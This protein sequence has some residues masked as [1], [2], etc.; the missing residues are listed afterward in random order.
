MNYEQELNRVRLRSFE[1]SLII[2]ENELKNLLLAVDYDSL[3]PVDSLSETI[4][5][6]K[7]LIKDKKQ[8][9]GGE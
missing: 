2:L 9:L 6:L 8:E 1:H 3:S 4:E 7:N 5:A